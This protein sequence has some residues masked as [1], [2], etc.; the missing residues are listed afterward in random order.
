MSLYRFETITKAKGSTL[1][2]LERR[3]NKV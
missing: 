1:E 3:K 2:I